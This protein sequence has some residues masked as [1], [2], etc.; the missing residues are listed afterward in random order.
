MSG[1]PFDSARQLQM[2]K[3]FE[4][5]EKLGRDMLRDPEGTKIQARIDG[6]M[7]RQQKHIER[8][9]PTWIACENRKLVSEH[10]EKLRPTL[11]PKY[12]LQTETSPA[13]LAHQAFKNVEMRI[14]NK[15]QKTQAIAERMKIKYAMTIA[16]RSPK[17]RMDI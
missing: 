14:E 15:L 17:T 7:K 4:K 13:A 9:K 12:I 10:R 6:V 16:Q 2:R 11:T 5:A 3:Q 8:H 1:Y